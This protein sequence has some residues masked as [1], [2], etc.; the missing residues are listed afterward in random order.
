M[1]DERSVARGA[2]PGGGAGSV[3]NQ[4]RCRN[5]RKEARA[6]AVRREGK[7]R[8]KC[9]SVGGAEGG[10]GLGEDWRLGTGQKPLAWS[11]STAPMRTTMMVLPAERMRSASIWSLR[12]S[13]S[14]TG[15]TTVRQDG[16]PTVM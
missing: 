5:G 16:M 6:G 15:S 14:G 8:G 4:T 2:E 1:S 12:V 9:C 13:T 10:G 3:G 7:L 11:T